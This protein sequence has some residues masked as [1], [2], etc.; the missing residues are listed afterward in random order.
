[1][2]VP[3]KYWF[4]NAFYKEQKTGQL[5][6]GAYQCKGIPVLDTKKQ[7]WNLIPF[8]QPFPPEGLSVTQF[9]KDSK[10]RLW[11]GTRSGLCYFDPVANLLR[12]YRTHDG[13]KLHLGETHV[14]YGLNEDSEGSLW[15]GTR[16]DGV[17]RID[18]TRTK[19]DYFKH[20]PG[21]CYSLLE[22]T[23]FTAI[24]TDK[25]N[26][27]WLG[28]RVGVSIY[29]PVKRIFYNSL[30]DTLR[31]YGII[32]SW[33]NGIEK[34]SLDRMWLAI[35]GAGLVRI[36][37]RSN[38]SFGIKLFHSGNGLND[39]G[40]GW[41]T[42]DPDSNFWVVDDGLQYFNPYRE[43]FR[44]FDNQNGLHENPGGS[45]MVYIDN[46]GNVFIGDS[47]GYETRNL[48][49]IHHAEKN[50]LNLV[51]EAIEVNGKENSGKPLGGS[52]RSQST[53]L[54]IRIT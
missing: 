6:V 30:Q 23:H 42:K 15:V 2:K 47:V 21:D 44:I 19:T 37:V 3:Y 39:P 54:P 11:V 27:V 48:K 49:T 41:I 5:F 53:L 40:V 50:A 38:G 20:T 7:S 22:G 36:E 9:Y 46:E 31:K 43:S 28:C 12:T 24:Q 17:I 14:V 35:D 18:P 29:D 16:F 33:I 34:D 52:P 4:I 8:D 10:S 25:F 51:L 1:M 32:K 13:E 45:Q 26:R